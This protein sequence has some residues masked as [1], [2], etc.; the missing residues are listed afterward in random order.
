MSH[1]LFAAA[2][3]RERSSLESARL[4]LRHGLWGCCTALIRDNLSTFLTPQSRGLVYVLKVGMCAEFSI[5]SSVLSLQDMDELLRDD[6][7]TEARFGFIRVAATRRWASS[8]QESHALLQEVL[9]IS[10]Q[11]ELSRRLSL[12]MHR[13]TDGEYE[14]IVGRLGPGEPAG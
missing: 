13:L 4:Q 3:L 7:R 2:T 10:D 1:F 14:A 9:R 12:G 8:P 5:L 6:L 11:A